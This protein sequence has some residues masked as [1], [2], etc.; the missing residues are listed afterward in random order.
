M[1]G[2]EEETP[3]DKQPLGS[4][5]SC[6]LLTHAHVHVLWTAPKHPSRWVGLHLQ[7][8]GLSRFKVEQADAAETV[9]KAA[10]KDKDEAKT[11][12]NL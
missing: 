7:P 6:R 3:E 9:T 8:D 4:D 1:V 5:L 12:T 10:S 11:A 2:R